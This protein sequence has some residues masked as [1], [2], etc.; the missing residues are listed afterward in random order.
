MTHQ[1]N[2]ALYL[3]AITQVHRFI[4]DLEIR[5]SSRDNLLSLVLSLG[6]ADRDLENEILYFRSISNR[7]VQIWKN[8]EIEKEKLRWINS[9][10]AKLKR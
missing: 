10:R 2:E 1:R 9:V 7:Q 6:P 4:F 3:F 8:C 5:E